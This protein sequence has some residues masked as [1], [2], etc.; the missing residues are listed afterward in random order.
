MPG[1]GLIIILIIIAPALLVS[2]FL[3][4]FVAL[5]RGHQNTVKIFLLTLFSGWTLIGWIIALVW[6]LTAV[7]PRIADRR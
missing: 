7:E 2:Y 4:F 6:A 5:L 3:P 1:W